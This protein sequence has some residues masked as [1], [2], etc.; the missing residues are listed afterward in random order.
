[1]EEEAANRPVL[2]SLYLEGTGYL[3]Q[4][5]NLRSAQG[6]EKPELGSKFSPVL[7]APCKDIPSF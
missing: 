7:C 4:Q 1:M 5:E 3:L 2:G 6:T